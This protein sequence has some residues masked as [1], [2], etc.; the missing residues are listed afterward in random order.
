MNDESLDLLRR[1]AK[2]VADIKAAMAASVGASASAL[3]VAS[4]AGGASG[5]G[6]AATAAELDGEHGDPIL[7]KDPPQWTGESFAGKRFSEAPVDYL[8][9][10]SHT[11]GCCVAGFNDWRAGKDDASGA[12]DNKGRPKS[13]WAKKDARIARG[14]S[15]RLRSGWKPAGAGGQAV[16]DEDYDDAGFGGDSEVPF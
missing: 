14:W 4:A 6:G 12:K 16:K 5:S 9:C 15:A 3:G 1:I 2:D 8:D 7:R 10:R 13:F 11:W